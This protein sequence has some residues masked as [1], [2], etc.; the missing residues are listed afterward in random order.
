MG[1]A[2]EH[3]ALES[4]EQIDTGFSLMA[5]LSDDRIDLAM[6]ALLIAKAAYPDLNKSFYLERLDRMAAGLRS[7]ITAKLDA[8]DI[9]A[10]INH[11]L[12][13]K[14]KLR[15]NRENYYDPD[16]SFLNRVLDRKIGI[17]I[18]LSLI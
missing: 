4:T 17:P 7:R 18:T 6:G 8:L 9:I 5:A 1:L 10:R 11:L 14:E 2:K 3:Q 12:F 13:D 15:G 16:N